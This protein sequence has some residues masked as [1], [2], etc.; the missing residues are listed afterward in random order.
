MNKDINNNTLQDNE[1]TEVLEGIE[2]VKESEA[3]EAKTD[4]QE[5]IDADF[6]AEQISFGMKLMENDDKL[7]SEYMLDPDEEG[8]GFGEAAVQPWKS[9]KKKNHNIKKIAI[10]IAAIV[11]AIALCG[12]IIFAGVSASKAKEAQAAP[13]NADEFP[14][15]FFDLSGHF[16][17]KPHKDS[18]YTAVSFDS[19]PSEEYGEYIKTNNDGSMLFF[20]DRPVADE[21]TSYDLY[22]R[23]TKHSGTQ[24]NEDAQAA[25]I[26]NAK[27]IAKS[28][29]G[30]FAV[31]NNGK[32]VAYLKEVVD[33]KGKLYI[34]DLSLET[35]IEEHDVT[36]FEFSD[37]NNYILYHKNSGEAYDLLYL[38]RIGD[39]SDPQRIDNNV[40]K[41]ISHTKDLSRIYYLRQSDLVTEEQIKNNDQSNDA[42]NNANN[43]DQ[44][45]ANGNDTSADES[46]QEAATDGMERTDVMC[47]LRLKVMGRDPIDIIDGVVNVSEIT[48]KGN[49]V[50]AMENK[51]VLTYDDLVED[52][53]VET[54]KLIEKPT[55]SDYNVTT[56]IKVD[57][58]GDGKTEDKVV[59]KIDYESYNRAMSKWN[60]RD[61]RDRTRKELKS[62][63]VEVINTGL[64]CFINGSVIEI[65]ADCEQY[66]P[67]D[68]DNGVIAYTQRETAPITKYSL[69]QLID[70]TGLMLD[71]TGKGE[72]VQLY[73]G[74]YRNSKELSRTYDA[75]SIICKDK[76]L[77]YLDEYDAAV[78][79]GTLYSIDA[80]SN[81]VKLA[82]DVNSFA[83]SGD[84]KT[85]AY[86]S[87]AAEGYGELFAVNNKGERT[88]LSNKVAVNDGYAVDDEGNIAANDNE[89]SKLIYW[90]GK[91]TKELAANPSKFVFRDVGDMLF[92]ADSSEGINDTL[93]HFDGKNAD[94]I[95]GGVAYFV[96]PY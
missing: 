55:M 45:N 68:I 10:I 88:L 42:A 93:F 58:N 7:I 33:G 6:S 80:Q 9:E 67:I 24:S 49:F 31:S 71:Q 8:L 22:Y 35:V 73:Y 51:T 53:Y 40:V 62:K 82:D 37:D 20:A 54:D 70:N 94:E 69:D 41:I 23:E 66:Y 11:A 77:Y 65:A 52:E 78:G 34:N 91:Q 75:Q 92:I 89:K 72:S 86:V 79:K 81:T 44:S 76:K 1:D 39:N 84:N 12:G 3:S 47:S 19:T 30:K 46:A 87:N 74:V 50:F 36:A 59:T 28:V 61:K 5:K 38:K 17:V 2:E 32:Y 63:N 29:M 14:V 43:N 27:C 15:L 95:I 16:N 18:G 90:N 56:T 57:E 26:S 85:Y 25:G 83:I 13:V 4:E 60:E 21:N 96:L 48:D 64:Y